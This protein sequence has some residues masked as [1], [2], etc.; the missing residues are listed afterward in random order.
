MKTDGAQK[1][2]RQTV[3][4]M[5][6][7]NELNY[8]ELEPSPLLFNQNRFSRT[9][10]MPYY[11]SRDKNIYFENGQHKETVAAEN[12]NTMWAA[13]GTDNAAAEED[14]V[15]SSS[16]LAEGGEYANKNVYGRPHR[17][18]NVKRKLHQQQRSLNP[19]IFNAFDNSGELIRND[20]NM[21]AGAVMKNDDATTMAAEKQLFA[22]LR[23]DATTRTCKCCD[24]TKCSE[25]MVANQCGC[26]AA[27]KL[28]SSSADDD[29]T[30]TT[31]LA[32]NR[33][34]VYYTRDVNDPN[35]CCDCTELSMRQEAETIYSRNGPKKLTST[36]TPNDGGANEGDCRKDYDETLK[37]INN[38]DVSPEKPLNASMEIKYPTEIEND[39]PG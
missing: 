5:Q 8:A 38:N 4:T 34:R 1:K 22:M 28:C 20:V 33:K 16:G 25:K 31:Q 12:A 14:D 3:G 18:R 6:Q 7:S 9:K 2:Q 17:R 30:K 21:F 39:F 26:C 23:K 32:Q 15:I 29:D 24:C 35:M 37:K 36:T 27:L 13:A 10:T 19:S 11:P